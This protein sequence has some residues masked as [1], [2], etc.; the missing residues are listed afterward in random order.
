MKGVQYSDHTAIT[1]ENV[2]EYGSNS[3]N[4]FQ[5]EMFY[6]GRIRISWLGIAAQ[7]GLVGLSAGLGVPAD[8]EETDLSNY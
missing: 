2:P 8:F 3:S 6:D 7:D 1:W 5:I 4:T